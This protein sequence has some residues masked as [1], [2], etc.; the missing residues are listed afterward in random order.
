MYSHIHRSI[1]ACMYMILVCVCVD[2]SFCLRMIFRNFVSREKVFPFFL[3]LP[4]GD[5]LREKNLSSVE[6]SHKKPM[7]KFFPASFSCGNEVNCVERRNLKII[8]ALVRS[9]LKLKPISISPQLQ[10]RE[11]IFSIDRRSPKKDDFSSK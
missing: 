6:K 10:K 11:E 3:V 4:P 2:N 1:H 9:P 5:K 7:E 8:Y